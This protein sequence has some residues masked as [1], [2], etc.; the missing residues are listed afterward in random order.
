MTIN[1][2]VD[3]TAT[4]INVCMRQ[5]AEHAGGNMPEMDM[6]KKMVNVQC[7]SRGK[8][9]KSLNVLIVNY[10]IHKPEMMTT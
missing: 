1:V 8:R 7:A 4:C 6:D 5:R 2:L 10:A 9:E 3:V